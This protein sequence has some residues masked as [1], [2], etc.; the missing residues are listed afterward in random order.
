VS[1]AENVLG[2]IQVFD[3]SG[4]TLVFTTT[5]L[6]VVKNRATKIG[7]NIAV[8]LGVICLFFIGILAMPYVGVLGGMVV[9]GIVTFI[10]V[11]V[12]VAL[13]HKSIDYC[14][15]SVASILCM[16]HDEIDYTQIEKVEV[17][18][19]KVT[20]FY[21]TQGEQR[22]KKWKFLYCPKNLDVLN[23]ALSGKIILK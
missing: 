22:K 7:S 10:L 13:T 1:Q 6:I 19:K 20:F 2:Y 5:R 11:S 18:K 9:G 16:S 12:I 4:Q 15:V 14:K 3:T 17:D 23:N 21:V 8:I